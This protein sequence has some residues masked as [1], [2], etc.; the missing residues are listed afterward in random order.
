L[1]LLKKENVSDENEEMNITTNPTLQ[2]SASKNTSRNSSEV[3]KR[4]PLSI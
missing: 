2:N 3:K 4:T 1:E